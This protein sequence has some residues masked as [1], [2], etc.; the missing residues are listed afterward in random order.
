VDSVADRVAVASTSRLRVAIDG[1]TGAGK[2]VFA[3]ELGAALRARDRSTLRASMDDFKFPWR[4]AREHCY[5]RVSGEGYYRNAY[6]FESARELLLRPAGARGSG[7]VVLCAFDP[8][9]GE[10]WRSISVDAPIDA[11]LIVDTV[12]AFRSEYNEFWDVRIWLEVEA[13][14]ALARGLA[15][16]LPM[17]GAN[18]ARDVHVNRYAVAEEIY[19]GETDPSRL[20]DIVID[21]TDLE[22]PRLVRPP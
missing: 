8:L 18:D 19:I 6:D 3:D 14:V 13:E 16:D 10:D 5:D 1:R 2:T 20:A 17:E 11:I 21:N 4:H 15:R 22:M 9:T 12:F 7:M